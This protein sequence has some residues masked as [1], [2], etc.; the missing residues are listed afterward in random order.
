[1]PILAIT[2]KTTTDATPNAMPTQKTGMLTGSSISPMPPTTNPTIAT[3]TAVQAAGVL[4]WWAM[5][6]PH[7]WARPADS[8]GVA[9]P[10]IGQGRVA[11]V[12]ER[13]PEVEA[14]LLT[15]WRG[16]SRGVVAAA[17]RRPVRN[18]ADGRHRG[19]R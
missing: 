18:E 8:L 10:P 12:V 17:H 6:A 19:H 9:G 4:P 14:G 13:A 5:R 1:M 16:R 7:R 2:A 3:V 15:G 11:S